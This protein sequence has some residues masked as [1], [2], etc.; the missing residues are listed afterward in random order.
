MRPKERFNLHINQPADSRGRVIGMQGRK[1]RCP[2][3]EARIAKSAVSE[4]R[5]SPIIIMSGSC[6][7][8]PLKILAGQPDL[9][10]NLNLGYSLNRVFHRVLNTDDF[11]LGRFRRLRRV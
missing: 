1:T 3:K 7:R 8:T 6:L 10:V 2:V 9:G 4:S 11:Y 5:I